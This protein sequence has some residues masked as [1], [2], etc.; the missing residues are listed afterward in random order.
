M[1]GS[2][3]N[4][5]R[6]CPAGFA[7][8]VLALANHQDDVLWYQLYQAGT[9]KDQYDSCPNYADPDAEPAAPAG[10]DAAKLCAAFA[11]DNVAEVQA[12]LSRSGWDE[13][14]YTFEVERHED[15]LRA[16]GL[17][18]YGVGAGYLYVSAGELPEGLT[19]A[20]L[21]VYQFEF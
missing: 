13:D 11:A 10:G 14:G 7:V 21:V 18:L 17:P 3:P 20:D 6:A 8:P 16:L 9:L 5:R 2:L 1:P 12:I 15:L 4:W 19:P